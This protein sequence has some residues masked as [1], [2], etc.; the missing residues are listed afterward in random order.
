M[1]VRHELISRAL[2]QRFEDVCERIAKLE[3]GVFGERGSFVS[4]VR[5]RFSKLAALHHQHAK[6]DTW[7]TSHTNCLSALMVLASGKEPPHDVSPDQPAPVDSFLK[8]LQEARRDPDRVVALTTERYACPLNF[9]LP[10]EV[11]IREY[12]LARLMVQLRLKAERAALTAGETE[13]VLLKLS[14]VA[15]NAAQTDDLRFIDALNYYYELLVTNRQPHF[16]NNR[17]LVSYL[18]LYAQTLAAWLSRDN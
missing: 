11:Q 4:E 2:Q 1:S 16:Q 12:L 9:L 7:S 3:D 10:G 5:D 13:D 6:I 14:L 8:Q 15:L 18:A 17:L